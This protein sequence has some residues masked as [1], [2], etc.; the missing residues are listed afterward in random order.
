MNYEYNLTLCNSSNIYSP[1]GLGKSFTLPEL[2]YLM[3]EM[4]C[5]LPSA[6]VHTERIHEYG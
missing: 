6:V 2:F 4:S 1:V 5:L 3:H